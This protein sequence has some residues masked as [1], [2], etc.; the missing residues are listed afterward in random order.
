MFIFFQKSQLLYKK[1]KNKA[2]RLRKEGVLALF[3]IFCAIGSTNR[4][5]VC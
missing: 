5:P 2:A 1:G 3:E 4:M